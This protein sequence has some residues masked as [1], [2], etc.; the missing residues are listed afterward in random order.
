MDLALLA[1]GTAMQTGHELCDAGQAEAPGGSMA[2]Q[3]LGH[4]K[5]RNACSPTLV[6]WL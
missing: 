1:E 6:W 4:L 2:P 3:G 5:A